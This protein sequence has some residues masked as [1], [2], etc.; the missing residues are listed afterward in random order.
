VELATGRVLDSASLPSRYFGEGIALLNGRIYQ[1]TWRA[2]KGFI[3]SAPDLEPRGSFRYPT[4]GWGLT[5]DGTHLILSDGTATLHFLDPESFET[6]RSV[7]V[8]NA[9]GP[10]SMLNELEWVE[11]VILANVWQQDVIVEVD[12]ATGAVRRELDFG[13][14]VAREGKQGPDAVL[15]GIA[16]DPGTRRLFVTGKLW[17]RVYEV[18][19]TGGPPGPRASP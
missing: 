5:T 13:P 3:Y 8:R 11:G 12:P 9:R 18:E 6:L 15:N 4:E 17:S 19:L 14:L 10:V 16:Y 7:E 1:L 2:R